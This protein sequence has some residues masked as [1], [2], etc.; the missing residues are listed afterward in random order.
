[1]EVKP[2]KRNFKKMKKDISILSLFV[3]IYCENLHADR[4]KKMIKTN[5]ILEEFSSE[6][7]NLL[8]K[9]C[10]ALLLHSATKRVLCPYEPKPA[11]KKCPSYC[12]ANGFRLKMREVMRFSG[13]YLIKKGRLDYIFKYFF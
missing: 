5:G 6:I 9:E 11:C 12:Y 7:S 1:M 8:C 2:L 4:N 10:E 3:R 13:A